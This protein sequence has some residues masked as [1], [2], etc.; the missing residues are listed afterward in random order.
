MPQ[1]CVCRKQM[2][3]CL[4]DVCF[5]AFGAVENFARVVTACPMPGQHRM[6]A[7]KTS[8]GM[9]R[10]SN[11]C[12]A[13]GAWCLGTFS[14]G[15]SV[16]LNKSAT[17]LSRT[18]SSGLFEVLQGEG[19][20]QPCA[21]SNRQMQDSADNLMQSRVCKAWC[22][23]NESTSPRHFKGG[24]ASLCNTSL[25]PIVE[26][27]LHAADSFLHPIT[28]SFTWRT[29]RTLFACHERTTAAS[30]CKVLVASWTCFAAPGLSFDDEP[31]LCA[32]ADV[33]SGN[34]LL[35]LLGLMRVL[36][37][38]FFFCC[39]QS[40]EGIIDCVVHALDACQLGTN[41][42]WEESRTHNSFSVETLVHWIL[43]ISK[44]FDF[45]SNKRVPMF[46]ERFCCAEQFPFCSCSPLLCWLGS[47]CG[48]WKQS[49]FLS[50]MSLLPTGSG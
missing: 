9:L 49:A 1:S 35:H 47:T 24:S 45:F 22:P 14:T 17:S 16:K 13:S 3:K 6:H 21:Q 15:P 36:Q 41:L 28:K 32:K 31:A 26:Q 43:V 39:F 38:R 11:P 8:P 44:D 30:Q 34:P 27:T 37:Q 29:S 18:G 5:K 20:S 25:V 4:R 46:L 7:S 50:A 40:T 12:S 23:S 19:S 2:A 42:F 48:H 10:C 33:Q